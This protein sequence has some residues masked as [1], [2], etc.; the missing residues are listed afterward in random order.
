MSVKGGEVVA[1]GAPM[2]LVIEKVQTI[3]SMFYRTIELIKDMPLRSR[4]A[5]TSDIQE[6]YRPWL[7]QLL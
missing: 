3:Q 5:S 4:G 6:S 7:F 1:G 2:D